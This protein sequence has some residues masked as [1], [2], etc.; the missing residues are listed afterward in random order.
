MIQVRFIQQCQSFKFQNRCRRKRN[1]VSD[2]T[3][4]IFPNFQFNLKITEVVYKIGHSR[5]LYTGVTKKQQDVLPLSHLRACIH[6]PLCKIHFW[7]QICALFENVVAN[8]L[9]LKSKRK[10]IR[11]LNGHHSDQ[12]TYETVKAA[13]Q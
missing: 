3:Q 9:Y 11:I 1:F 12:N 13:H 8:S 10:S 2:Y 7:Q 5:T 4:K 6:L